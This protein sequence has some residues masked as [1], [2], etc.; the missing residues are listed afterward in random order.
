[1]KIRLSALSIA[2]C[3]AM[4]AA[5]LFAASTTSTTT[6]TKAAEVRAVWPAES[7][8]GTITIVD[9][10]LKT[11]VVQTPGGV[12]FD[13]VVNRNTRI[14]AGDRAISLQD[15]QQDVNKGVSVKFVP[16][17]RGDVATTIQLNG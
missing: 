3:A 17:R 6:S 9:P 4:A 1:M 15:L 5:P 7:L 8:S 12:P 2:A 13:M 14:K 10:A 16:E 11:V